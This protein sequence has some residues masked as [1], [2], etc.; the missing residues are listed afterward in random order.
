MSPKILIVDDEPYVR[1]SIAE[2]L[3][4][5]GYQA[6]EAGSGLEALKMIAQDKPDL[7]FLDVLMPQMNGLLVLEKIK[8]LFPEIVV[9][10]VTAVQEES[11]AREAI[12]LGA[13]DYVTKPINLQTLEQDYIKRIFG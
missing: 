10:M 6:S 1:N 13:F 5:Q 11:N 9:V 7:V 8:T 4:G 12:R 2:Y 3:Q